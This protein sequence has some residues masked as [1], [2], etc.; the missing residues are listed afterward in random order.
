MEYYKNSIKKTPK[1]ELTQKEK[2][3]PDLILPIANYT[4]PYNISKDLSLLEKWTNLVLKHS[5][6]SHK[7]QTQKQISY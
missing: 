5:S 7:N 6:T 1:G 4:I 2:L 3:N